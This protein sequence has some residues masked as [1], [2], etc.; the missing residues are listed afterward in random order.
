MGGKD[1]AR[2]AEL[3]F[4]DFRRL[5]HDEALSPYERIGFPDDYREGFERAIFE[6]IRRKLPALDGSGSV[7]VDIGP[8]CSE[9]PQM[10]RTHCE[11]RDHHL[12]FVDSSEMLDH[13]A[14]GPGL[15]KVPG[16]FPDV[17]AELGEE[18]GT[19]AA[20]LAYS[21]IQYVFE[22]GSVFG[23]LDAALELLAPGGAL[24]IG[25]LPNASMR[26]RYF[27]SDAGQAR[28]KEFAQDDSPPP[29]SFNAIQRGRMD[30]AVVLS[31]VARARAAGFHA[32]IVPQ[33]PSLPMANRREDLLVVR[34]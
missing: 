15:R 11:E 32:W 22:D 3:S 8:G 27:A 16:R 18:R 14:D 5:A 6:D 20:V 12:V 7:V 31:L 4:D 21:V 34:P 29:V 30:D 10:L 1:Y 9:L 17:A 13:H 24:L 19:A 23:F 33:D 28:H 2:F 25:D 26:S